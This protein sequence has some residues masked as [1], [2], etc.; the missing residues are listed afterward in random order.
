MILTIAWRNIWRNKRRSFVL[1]ITIAIGSFAILG[2]QAFVN[3]FER[4]MVNGSLDFQ[5][6][7]V[8]I[9]APGFRTQPSIDSFIEQGDALESELKAKI[10]L[11]WS[12]R[13]LLQG[14]ASSPESATAAQIYG[15]VPERERSVSLIADKIIEGTFLTQEGQVVIGVDMADHLDLRLGEKMVLMVSGLSKDINANAFRIIGI[16]QSGYQ[17]VDKMR[18]YVSRHDAARLAE[19]DQQLNMV[20]IKLDDPAQAEPLANQLALSTPGCEVL[21]WRQLN[22]FLVV[23]LESFKY[24][25]WIFGGIM[26]TA[27][28]FSIINIFLMVIFERVREI[29][30]TLALGAPPRVIRAMLIWE[31]LFVG[32]LGCFVGSVTAFAFIHPLTTGGLDLSIV[33]EGLGRFGISPIIHPFV[34]TSDQVLAVLMTLGM[35][36]LASLYPAIKASRFQV[37]DAIHFQ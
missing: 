27:I 34:T 4:Q 29:G 19:Y 32:L 14:M 30:I 3:A 28:A 20:A 36:V 2:T 24:N 35:S 11:K 16:F 37:V 17:D 18:V 13:V 8:E 26:L 33:S 22:P 5:T 23:S 31:T 10:G 12:P 15:V 1:I 7:S 21:H 9:A 25:V 6:A